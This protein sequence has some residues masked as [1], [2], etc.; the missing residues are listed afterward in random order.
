MRLLLSTIGTR[1]D[2][3]PLVALA[4]RLRALG[5]D[6]RLCAP[7]DFREWIEGL[8]LAVTPVGRE[9][10]RAT[11]AG[12]PALPSPE[13]LRQLMEGTVGAQFEA[14]GRAAEGCDVVVAATSLQM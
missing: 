12:P 3:Q 13:R 11:M 9:L 1:G 5:Q 4:L 6:V 14:V 7:P 8:G 10:R 2:V